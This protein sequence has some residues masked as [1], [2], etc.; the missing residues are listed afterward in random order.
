[1]LFVDVDGV[2][3]LFPV[4]PDTRPVDGRWVTVDGIVHLVST[5]AGRLLRELAWDFELVWCTGWE[6]KANEY[7]PAA[8]GLEAALPH[9]SFE[10]ARSG[11]PS[12]HWKLAAIERYAGLER[13]VAWIDD[14]HEESCARW[15]Q[16]RPGPTLLVTTEPHRGLTAAEAARLR[17]WARALDQG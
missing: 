4:T 16:D 15:A 8:L 5:E 12:R 6:E 10:L 17:S 1:L 2:I 3:S 13:P 9:L 11:D 7:L 14:D